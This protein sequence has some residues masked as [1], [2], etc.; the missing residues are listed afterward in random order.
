M[1]IKPT[2]E[3]IE[4]AKEEG[5]D[6]VE[7]APNAKPPVVRIM[8]YGKFKY[9]KEQKA[10]R[11]K[12]RQHIVE[13]KEIKFRP[14]ISSG[15]YETKKRHIERFLKG[16][17]KVKV[18]LMF[19][20]REQAHPE[21]GRELLERLSEDVAEYSSIESAPKRDGRNMIMVLSSTVKQDKTQNQQTKENTKDHPKNDKDEK[22]DK[23][24]KTI[25]DEKEEKEEKEENK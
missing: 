25:K 8:D 24:E 15:D 16:G 3:A 21:L 20:G 7:I 23:S 6:L 11:A 17:A 10:K 13:V 22:S 14:K 18:T 2:R 1:G 9:E 19:R 5:F 12:K 4:I